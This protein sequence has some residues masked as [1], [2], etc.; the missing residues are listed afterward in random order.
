[1]Q[2]CLFPRGYLVAPLILP[3]AGVALAAPTIAN[4]NWPQWRGPLQNGVAPAA[5][6]PT[7]WS[8]TNNIKWK[9]KIPGGGNA[10]PIIWDNL[11]FVQTAVP[12]GKKTE[13]KPGE[14]NAPDP[15][16]VARDEG[17]GPGSGG[18]G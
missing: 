6:P 7:V 10:T 8:E 11:V 5:T 17:R 18:P 4:Q 14:T 13:P 1:M 15:A 12:T 3:V 2:R 16:Q 9:V